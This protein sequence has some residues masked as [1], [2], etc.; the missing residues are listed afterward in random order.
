MKKEKKFDGMRANDFVECYTK[1]NYYA[2]WNEVT[3]QDR[4][5]T[6]TATAPLLSF[7]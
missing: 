5:A 2:L 3:Y 4:A 6:A 1:S 7:I